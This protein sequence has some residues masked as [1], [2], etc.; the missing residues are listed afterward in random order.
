MRKRKILEKLNFLVVISVFLLKIFP[1][2]LRLIFFNSI[3]NC[4]GFLFIGIRYILLKTLLKSCGNNVSIHKGVILLGLDNLE[5]E[6]NVSIH[7]FCYI[8]GTG[9]LKIG[10]DI[11]IAHSSTILSTEHLYSNLEVPIKDQGVKL[12]PTLLEGNIWVA[13]GVRILAG[14]HISN[15]VIIAAGAVVKGYLEPNNIYGGVPA[16]L[17]KER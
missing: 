12:I 8:D 3:Q 1:K 11:S 9:G 7:P 2:K 6:D 5:I 13:C 15:G 17:I 4:P 14:S 16:R 10:N